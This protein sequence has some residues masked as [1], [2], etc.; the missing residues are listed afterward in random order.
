MFLSPL[1]FLCTAA[2]AAQ[3]VS[4]VLKHNNEQSPSHAQLG[5]SVRH[6]RRNS[7]DTEDSDD[8]A[9]E[10]LDDT[11]PTKKKV[12]VAHLLVCI[13]AIILCHLLCS[14]HQLQDAVSLKNVQHLLG[15]L[16]CP[17]NGPLNDLHHL[18]HSDAPLS[19]Q[20]PGPPL[21]NCQSLNRE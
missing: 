12:K 16:W 10:G 1:L 15:P 11:P 8:S 14:L 19:V 20:N 7:T 4:N 21:Q 3:L 5:Q 18:V 6:H 17:L 2:V 9:E 13:H